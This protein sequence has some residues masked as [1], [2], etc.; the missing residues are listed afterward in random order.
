MNRWDWEGI[1]ML[2]MVIACG[3]LLLAA[4]V[5]AYLEHTECSRRGGV[6]VGTGKYVIVLNKVGDVMVPQT[7]KK[8]VCSVPKESV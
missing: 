5:G 1:V 2:S 4:I 6:M 8:R 7:I 3:L